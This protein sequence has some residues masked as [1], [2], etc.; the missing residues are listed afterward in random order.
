MEE[1]VLGERE[2]AYVAVKGKSES[3]SEE[4][5]EVQEMELKEKSHLVY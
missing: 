3:K 5:V 2:R 4:V 1:R